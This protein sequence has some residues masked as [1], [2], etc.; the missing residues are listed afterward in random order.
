[1]EAVDFAA[2][3]QE[4]QDGGGAG[5]AEHGADG[6]GLDGAE[7]ETGGDEGGD[8]AGDKHLGGAGHQRCCAKAF[9][10]APGEFQPQAEEEEGNA[11]FGDGFDVGFGVDEAEAAGTAEEHAGEQVANE[12]TLSQIGKHRPRR[13]AGRQQYDDLDQ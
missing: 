8:E 6:D 1:M 3:H 10:S 11:Q 12:R 2:V 13:Q 5:E 4:A 9:Q 7:A